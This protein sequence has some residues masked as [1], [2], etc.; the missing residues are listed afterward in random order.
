VKFPLSPGNVEVLLHERGIDIRHEN[1]AFL[2]ERRYQSKLAAGSS[3]SRCG[4]P[5]WELRLPSR[6]SQ[7]GDEEDGHDDTCEQDHVDEHAHHAAFVLVDHPEAIADRIR[8]RHQ[9]S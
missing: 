3:A 2:V 7:P 5:G 8:G 6:D 9:K 1:G 4:G